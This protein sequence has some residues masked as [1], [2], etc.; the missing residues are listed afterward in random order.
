[1][2]SSAG[3]RKKVAY[4]ADNALT[5]MPA[6]RSSNQLPLAVALLQRRIVLLP[7]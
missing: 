7:P 4:R 6:S 2:S 5:P 1:M 3:A